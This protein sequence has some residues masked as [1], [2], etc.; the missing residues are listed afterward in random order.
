MKE[1]KKEWMHGWMDEWVSE[2][3]R[4]RSVKWMSEWNNFIGWIE[5]EHMDGDHA[6][7]S[8]PQSINVQQMCDMH[9][10]V[11]HW[12]GWQVT[13]ERKWIS[14][15]VG[16]QSFHRWPDLMSNV[17]HRDFDHD[18]MPEAKHLQSEQTNMQWNDQ[19]NKH[20]SDHANNK[21]SKITIIQLI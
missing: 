4:N 1:W 18:W 19:T 16:N 2:W 3:I 5:Q 9:E 13:S 15:E 20:S 21:V 7:Q 17:G 12:I 6:N 10:C 14:K 11:N 8:I